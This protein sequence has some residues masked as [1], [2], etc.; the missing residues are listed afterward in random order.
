M[1]ESL[2]YYVIAP[3]EGLHLTCDFAV[4][5]AAHFGSPPDYT[6]TPVGV[7]EGY[8]EPYQFVGQIP[9]SRYPELAA[10]GRMDADT[11]A[12]VQRVGVGRMNDQTCL[13]YEIVLDRPD[14]AQASSGEANG[15][16][17]L[18]LL[19]RGERI[20]DVLRLYLFRPGEDRSIGR[21]GAIDRGIHGA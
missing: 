13:A 17:L 14:Y 2:S 18:W 20:L 1:D 19:E 9:Y 5:S 12:A 4:H 16:L 7:H 3:V 6:P 15:S 8:R 10:A 11:L 21:L